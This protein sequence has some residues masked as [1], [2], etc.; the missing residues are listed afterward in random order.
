MVRRNPKDPLPKILNQLTDVDIPRSAWSSWSEPG[1][2][3]ELRRHLTE[4]ERRALEVRRRELEPVMTPFLGDPAEASRVMLSIAD[5]FSGYRSMRQTGEAAMATLE[6]L[7]RA[8][9]DF[10][11]WSIEK[12]CRSIQQN[13]VWRDGKFD[14]NWP[15]NDAEVIDAVRKEVEVYKRQYWNAVGL[16]Q[17]EVEIH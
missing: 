5:V 13:G 17:A 3:R 14:R 10:P 12:A 4:D 16:L 7:A 1:K 8:L 11:F 2:P 6:S 15:P 9:H